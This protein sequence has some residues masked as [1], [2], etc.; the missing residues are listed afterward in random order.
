SEVLL[1]V[2]TGPASILNVS[3]RTSPFTAYVAAGT[4]RRY[5][6][7]TGT[8]LMYRVKEEPADD[9][10]MTSLTTVTRLFARM[11]LMSHERRSV[12]FTSK[13]SPN[14]SRPD[15]RMLYSSRS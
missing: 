13:R 11:P 8:P 7:P 4:G 1:A 2:T 9:C 6:S 10:A 3:R 12:V 5:C 14:H 15:L